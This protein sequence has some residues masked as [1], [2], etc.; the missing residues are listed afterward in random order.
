MPGLATLFN[1]MSTSLTIPTIDLGVF[2][3]KLSINNQKASQM[4]EELEYSI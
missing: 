3:N 1:K 2:E 4:L